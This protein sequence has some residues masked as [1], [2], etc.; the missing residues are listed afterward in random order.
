[1]T[2]VLAVLSDGRVGIEGAGGVLFSAAAA[3][4]VLL[5][6]SEARIWFFRDSIAN[7]DV[8]KALSKKHKKINTLPFDSGKRE[9][10]P[11]SVFHVIKRFLVILPSSAHANT[12]DQTPLDKSGTCF[13][14]A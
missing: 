9:G 5:A 2:S 8:S 3:A 14:A 11:Y 6:G 12:A 4:N 10:K 7:G 1:M 13:R